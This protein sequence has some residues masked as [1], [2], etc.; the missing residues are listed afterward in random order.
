MPL[1]KRE[2]KHQH[3]LAEQR[4]SGSGFIKIPGFN[5]ITPNKTAGRS[6]KS[7]YIAR[8]ISSKNSEHEY[9]PLSFFLFIMD[10]RN[11]L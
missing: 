9:L 3:N 5:Y 11:R 2:S 1:F 4:Q 10:G 7:R 8:I 6:C